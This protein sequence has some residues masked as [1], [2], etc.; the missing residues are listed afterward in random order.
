MRLKRVVQKGSCTRQICGG[1]EKGSVV[2]LSKDRR[3]SHFF[4]PAF[5]AI[6]QAIIKDLCG[7]VTHAASPFF[8]LHEEP[9][10][11]LHYHYTVCK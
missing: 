2:E 11:A 3:S 1:A 10:A 9:L 5:D 4:L 7:F 8:F 6:V